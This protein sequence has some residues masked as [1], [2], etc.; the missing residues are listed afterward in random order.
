[1]DIVA[2]TI[3][4]VALNAVWYTIIFFVWLFLAFLPANIARSKG[5]SFWLYFLISLFFWW[6]TLFVVLFQKDLT[7]G[8]NTPTAP[9]V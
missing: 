4:G 8:D 9:A 1:M 6:I 3:F 5:R 2:T 7:R